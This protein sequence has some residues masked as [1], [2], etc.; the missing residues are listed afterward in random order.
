MN[1]VVKDIDKIIDWY[2]NHYR[3]ASLHNLMDAKTKLLT[4]CYTYS[5]EVAES[6]RGSVV[7]TAFRKA[8]H[9]KIKSQL[10]DEGM[11]QGAAESRTID[12]IRDII[13][14][15][16]ER[17]ALAYRTRLV[18]DIALRISEDLSQRIS[19]LKKEMESSRDS[20]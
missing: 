17:E 8:E 2:N 9:H 10:I 7:A 5:E 11:A 16:A 12:E 15:E 13:N 6:K 20:V 18:L 14:E 4:L 19:V 3:G 1:T